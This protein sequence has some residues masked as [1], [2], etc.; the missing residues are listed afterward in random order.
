MRIKE[1][2]TKTTNGFFMDIDIWKYQFMSI[3]YDF[4]FLQHQF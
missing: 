3:F 4:I 2:N 1:K